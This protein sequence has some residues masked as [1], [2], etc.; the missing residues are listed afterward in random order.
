MDNPWKHIDLSDY[1]RHMGDPGV[2]QLQAFSRILQEQMQDWRPERVCMLG[3]GPGAG[4]E[5]VDKSFVRRVFLLDINESYLAE[6]LARH[7]DLADLL[8][9]R[10]C[11]LGAPDVTLPECDLMEANLFIEYIGVGVFAALVRRNLDKFKVLSCTIQKNNANSFV[12]TSPTAHKLVILGDLHHDI[13]E[14]ELT[15]ALEKT[16]LKAVKRK[17]YDLPNGKEFIRLDYRQ[18]R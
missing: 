17:V 12:S 16:G 4:L 13:E 6:S 7:P 3:G 8:E 2:G 15:A 5:H 11:D 1:E 18:N 9:T 14:S 10:V